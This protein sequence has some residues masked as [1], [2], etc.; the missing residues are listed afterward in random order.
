MCF[1]DVDDLAELFS[2]ASTVVEQNPSSKGWTG[3]QSFVN[4]MSATAVLR[5]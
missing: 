2:L 4:E 3:N 5:P 1:Y